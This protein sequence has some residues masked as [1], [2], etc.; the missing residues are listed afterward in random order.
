MYTNIKSLC[1]TPETNITLYQLYLNKNEFKDIPCFWTE[2]FG[3]VKMSILFK[4]DYK[5]YEISIKIQQDYFT[6]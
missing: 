2:R 3:V 6:T 1:C 4:I 5:L